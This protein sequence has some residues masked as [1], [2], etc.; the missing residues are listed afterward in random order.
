MVAV[1]TMMKTR[2][3]D[4]QPQPAQTSQKVF[5]KT[6]TFL[7]ITQQK[8]SSGAG[9]FV[10]EEPVVTNDA[11]NGATNNGFARKPCGGFYYH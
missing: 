7:K 8:E 4:Y 9:G 5:N 3:N 1:K 2:F 11:H 6:G 10:V